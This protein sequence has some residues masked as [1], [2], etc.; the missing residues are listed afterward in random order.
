MKERHPGSEQTTAD[1]TVEVLTARGRRLKLT[2]DRIRAC[3]F[4]QSGFLAP[5][6]LRRIRLRHEQFLR[7]LAARLAVLLRIE[8]S[9]QIERIGIVGY[10]KFVESLP[11]PAHITLFRIEPLKGV[12]LL[13]VPPR[14]GLALVDRLLG[15]PG[16][17]PEADRD[18]SEIEVALLDQ[19]QDLLLKEWCLHWPEMRE[20]RPTILGHETHS[21]FLQTAPPDAATLVLCLKGGPGEYRESWQLAFPYVTLEPLARLLAPTLGKGQAQPT[22]S[23]QLQWKPEFDDLT[24]PVSVEW[25][26]LQMTAGDLGRLRPGSVLLLDGSAATV[27]LRLNG[28]ARFVGRPGIKG[29]RWAVELKAPLS[30]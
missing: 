7:S 2:P 16:L 27:R 8:F 13:V 4:R 5:S 29:G 17:P 23:A 22:E 26:G 11:Q 14:W 1:G 25:A 15:G 19:I 24:V 18:L 20:L 9:L 28:V 30:A 3:D 12:G 10:Q 21:R 6:E